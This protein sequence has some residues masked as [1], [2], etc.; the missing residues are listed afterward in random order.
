MFRIEKAGHLSPWRACG[1][2]WNSRVNQTSTTHS[3]LNK[4]TLLTIKPPEQNHHRIMS[5]NLPNNGKPRIIIIGGG[6]AGINLA[7]GLKNIDATVTMLDR[8]NFHTFQPLL[9]QV[10]TSGLEVSSI[11]YPLRKV[12]GR[13]NFFFRMADVKH[14]DAANNKIETSIGFIEYDYL[15]IAT[16]TRNNYFN[17]ADV[18]ANAIPL[19]SISEAIAMRNYILKNFEELLLTDNEQD[20]QALLNFVIAGGGPTG[21]ELAGAL[22]ELKRKVLPGDYPELD[23]NKMRI[24]LLDP[25]TRILGAF[26]EEASAKALEYLTDFGVEVRL[27]LGIKSYDGNN[28]ILSSGEELPTKIL[29]WAAG[30]TGDVPFGLQPEA[31]MR[32]NRIKVDEYCKVQ[33]T[34]NIFALG[35]IA[36][37]ETPEFPK[38]LPGL[39]PVAIQQGGYM[40]RHIRRLLKNEK[41]EPF[42]YFDK[43]SLATIG[44]NK[45]VAD[46][47][48]N[49]KFQGF[50][51]WLVWLVVH[52]FFLIGFRNKVVVLM[53]WFWSYITYDRRVRLIIAP[54]RRKKE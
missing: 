53:D 48:G 39:A 21:V 51:A 27:G 4:T 1:F 24:I 26:S 44:R 31:I 14:I 36:H 50:F 12:L 20:K 43:G 15:V 13:K 6:F 5:A 29:I 25:G 33:G 45:A 42:K 9:Y 47:P 2:P 11:A 40:A 35:D 19:K 10:A 38:G 37:F 49:I 8:N 34:Q 30:V 23:L 7:K 17:M 52:L 46:M 41:T 18:E 32:G 22:S 3:T 16:G 54:F 28:A